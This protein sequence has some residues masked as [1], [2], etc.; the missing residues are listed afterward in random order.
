MI[1]S[2]LEVIKIK[3]LNT[4]LCTG[5]GGKLSVSSEVIGFILSKLV[6]GEKL[7]RLWS[8]INVS[9]SFTQADGSLTFLKVKDQWPD[10]FKHLKPH[11]Y[12]SYI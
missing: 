9:L 10:V 2:S 1:N 8:D 6:N 12:H 7:S 5:L 4:R 11:Q 3:G